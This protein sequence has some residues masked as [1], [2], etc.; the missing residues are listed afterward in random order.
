MAEHEQDQ[1]AFIALL[2]LG[3]QTKKITIEDIEI[4]IKKISFGEEQN[5]ANL[6]GEMEQRGIPK[7]TCER[8]YA[9]QVAVTGMVEPKFDEMSINDI[10]FPM[11]GTIA[12]AVID[13][14]SGLGKNS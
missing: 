12:R 1:V 13:F 14:S 10:P 3:K 8:E 4:T 7:D 11:V 6:V 9:K 2:E 5:I